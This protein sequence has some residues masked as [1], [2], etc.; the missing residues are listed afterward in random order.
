MMSFQAP[1]FILLKASL[2][3]SDAGTEVGK[4]GL[5]SNF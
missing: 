5:S 1:S 2:K 4:F 3:T